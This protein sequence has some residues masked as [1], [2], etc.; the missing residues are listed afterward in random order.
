ME[1]YRL[2]QPTELKL[3]RADVLDPNPYHV[4]S[5][6]SL[7]PGCWI[8]LRRSAPTYGKR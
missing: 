7:M 4:V 3:Q 2:Q 1:R 8:G 6:C 5:Q